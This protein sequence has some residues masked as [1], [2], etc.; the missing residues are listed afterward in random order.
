MSR[1]VGRDV[2][3]DVSGNARGSCQ[4]ELSE[5]MPEGAVSG[6]ARGDGTGIWSAAQEEELG[7]VGAGKGL[8][9]GYVFGGGGD[10]DGAEGFG[11]GGL[12]SVSS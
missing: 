4:R 9:V 12:P 11:G 6:N 1:N 3:R 5:E 8:E 2:S 10:T 7:G